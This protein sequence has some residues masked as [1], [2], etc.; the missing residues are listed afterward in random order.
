VNYTPTRV[1]VTSKDGVQFVVASDEAAAAYERAF[2][3][4]YKATELEAHGDFHRLHDIGQMTFAPAPRIASP[5]ERRKAFYVIPGG[6]N[7]PR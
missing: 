3:A 6:K 5:Q 1:I 2:A 7:G 4:N